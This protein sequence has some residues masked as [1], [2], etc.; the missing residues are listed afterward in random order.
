M[1]ELFSFL[2]SLVIPIALTRLLLKEDYGTYQQ[3]IMVYTIIQ[4]I[5][6]LGMPQALLYYY[7]RISEKEYP[8]LV[9]QTWIIILF[10]GVFVALASLASSHALSQIYP[11]HHLQP[12][13]ILLGIY[14]GIMLFVMPLQNL[15]I[16]EEKKL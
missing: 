2:I 15:I 5:L 10:S 1:G 11:N 8:N 13:V 14:T 12:F 16:L 9:K 4:S 6:L 3:L 7:P